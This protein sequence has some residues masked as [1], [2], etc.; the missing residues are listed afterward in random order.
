MI[1]MKIAGI[2]NVNFKARFIKNEDYYKVIDYAHNGGKAEG[3]DGVYNFDSYLR[4]VEK[5][6]PDCELEITLSENKAEIKNLNNGKKIKKNVHFPQVRTARSAAADLIFELSDS[7]S[8]RNTLFSNNSIND[9]KIFEKNDFL[10]AAYEYY[11]NIYS[12][13]GFHN[14]VKELEHFYP[15]TRLSVYGNDKSK[16]LI[17][18]NKDAQKEYIISYRKYR[19]GYDSPSIETFDKVLSSL[20]LLQEEPMLHNYNLDDRLKLIEQR[21]NEFDELRYA[22]TESYE[23]LKAKTIYPSYSK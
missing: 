12:T 15:E 9:I 2:S 22:D 18:K 8:A 3:C 6:C 16:S 7:S 23:Y 19:E 5:N 1:Y 17:I 13:Q 20:M 4:S 21:Y 10:E 14:K 11:Q